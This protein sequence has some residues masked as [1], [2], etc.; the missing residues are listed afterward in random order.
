VSSSLVYLF[1][2][3]IFSLKFYFIQVLVFKFKKEKL[4]GLKIKEI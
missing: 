3:F 1:K 4:K 2:I